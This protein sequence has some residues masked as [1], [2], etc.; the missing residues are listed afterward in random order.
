[1]SNK[2]PVKLMI[3]LFY[4]DGSTDKFYSFN[5]PK[6]GAEQVLINTENGVVS[7]AREDLMKV[8]YTAVLK[9]L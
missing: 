1:M 7:V 5:L 3:T 6:I 4:L 9:E 2:D 8:R